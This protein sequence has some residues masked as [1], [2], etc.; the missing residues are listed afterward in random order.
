M[1][2]QTRV[3]HTGRQGSSGRPTQRTMW[4]SLAQ[5]FSTARR[6]PHRNI[7]RLPKFTR[8]HPKSRL[9]RKSI[10]SAKMP[11]EIADI[12]KVRCAGVEK[13]L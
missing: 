7:S 8:R 13:K 10:T 5:L 6:R 3:S 11:Q 2:P 9:P 12:K 4:G 1:T